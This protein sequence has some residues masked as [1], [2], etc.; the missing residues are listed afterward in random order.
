MLV[1]GH[2]IAGRASVAWQENR[3]HITGQYQC[4]T[5]SLVTTDIKNEATNM[6]EYPLK[7]TQTGRTPLEVSLY[8]GGVA[9]SR[10]HF[11]EAD[12]REREW[13]ERDVRIGPLSRS[14]ALSDRETRTAN[15]S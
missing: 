10:A 4:M 5:L 14:G 7:L 8:E 2:K 12:P 3:P 11:S 13:I 1:D 9:L 15:V 6:S